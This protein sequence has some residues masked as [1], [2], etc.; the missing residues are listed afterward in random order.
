M[1]VSLRRAAPDMLLTA[2]PTSR[3]TWRRHGIAAAAAGGSLTPI[4]K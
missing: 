4:R 1:L 3:R 2:I